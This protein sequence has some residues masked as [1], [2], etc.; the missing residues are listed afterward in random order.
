MGAG[1]AV[2]KA[3]QAQPS[4]SVFI[5]VTDMLTCTDTC[6]NVSVSLPIAKKSWKVGNVGAES[7]SEVT[8]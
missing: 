3:V 5:F 6:K 1:N 7:E 2:H 4:C 8:G